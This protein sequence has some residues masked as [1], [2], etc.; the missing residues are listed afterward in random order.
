MVLGEVR[1]I[2]LHFSVSFCMDISYI[3]TV[4]ARLLQMREYLPVAE[5]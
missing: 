5:V 1:F 4:G 2:Y 3:D